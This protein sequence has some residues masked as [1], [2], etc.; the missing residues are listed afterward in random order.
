ML[1]LLPM[2]GAAGSGR[3]EGTHG[4]VDLDENDNVTPTLTRPGSGAR[5]RVR[6]GRPG[7]KALTT[8]PKGAKRVRLPPPQTCADLYAGGRGGAYRPFAQVWSCEAG[9]L[10]KRST[11][12]GGVICPP[13]TTPGQDPNPD[14]VEYQPD[15]RNMVRQATDL[16]PLPEPMLSPPVDRD[17][18]RAVVGLP[19]FFAIDPTNWRAVAPSVTD[20]PAFLTI[21]ATPIALDVT[22]GDGATL[23][24]PGPGV[25]VTSTEQAKRARRTTCHHAYINRPPKGSDVV[26]T[27]TTTWALR[28]ITNLAPEQLV[29]V[30]PDTITKSS[31]VAVPLTQYQAVLV[32]PD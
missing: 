16:I 30:L 3:D 4:S 26:A 27:L 28:P 25:R 22:T 1:F 9:V 7:S 14:L 2:S 18:V 6:T 8:Q 21:E 5:L 13:D 29:G 20:G 23:Q 32:D 15:V 19:V 11:C 31:T 12:Y 10:K 17:G 24:C